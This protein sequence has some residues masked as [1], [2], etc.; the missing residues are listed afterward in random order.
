MQ[1]SPTIPP[2]D[3]PI[4]ATP[5]VAVDDLTH[6]YASASTETD[7]PAL[8]AVSFTVCPG[9]IFGILG[10]NGG[11]KTTLFRI[12]ATTLRPTSGSVRVFD[13][14]PVAHPAAVRGQLGVVFQHPSLDVKLTAWENLLHQGHLYGLSGAD[15]RDRI[16]RALQA[17]GLFD[18]RDDFVERFSG[19]MRRRVEIA[20]AVLHAPR[21]LL[22]DEPATGLDP[23]ARRDVWRQLERL[24]DEE[25][26]TIAL[27]THLMDEADRCDRL[28]ILS[29]GKLVAQGTPSELKS[30]IGGDVVSL[31]AEPAGDPAAADELARLI[32]EKFG[33]WEQGSAPAVIDGRVRIERDRGATFVATLASA[34]PGKVRSITVGRPTLDD[35]FMHVTG[36]AMTD[37]PDST[38][39]PPRS[40]SRH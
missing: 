17:V 4:D 29:G 37:A 38:Q 22:L 1:A 13:E 16:T 6:R 35:V 39:P 26:V 27:T 24:R 25:G 18:R 23:G 7:R 32:T 2:A 21:L 40:R 34:F 20:K 3:A 33:P 15:L 19:G 8:D 28:A 9:E 11:G 31:E 36:R 14:D 5:A 12:L 10:P 30:R